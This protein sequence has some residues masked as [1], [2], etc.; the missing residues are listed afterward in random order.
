MLLDHILYELSVAVDIL[1]WHEVLMK[2]DVASYVWRLD[3]NYVTDV[4]EYHKA[5]GKVFPEE[6]S[7]QVEL[8]IDF[9]WVKVLEVL[10]LYRK[11]RERNS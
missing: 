11:H 10:A 7:I 9:L 3:S 2:F 1:D 6:S 8:Y 4:L 5:I